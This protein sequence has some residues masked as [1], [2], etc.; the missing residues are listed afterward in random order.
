MCVCIDTLPGNPISIH[1]SV[2]KLVVVDTAIS[3]MFLFSDFV[4]F[5]VL[6]V[7]VKIIISGLIGFQCGLCDL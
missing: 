3:A 1:Y 7:V 6:F 5:V 2:V 4:V